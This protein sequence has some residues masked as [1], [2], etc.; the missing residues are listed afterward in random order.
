LQFS[1]ER[2]SGIDCGDLADLTPLAAVAGQ[3][4][5]QGRAQRQGSPR[6]HLG[7][8]SKT[9]PIAAIRIERFPSGI[10]QMPRQLRHPIRCLQCAGRRRLKQELW[11]W[12]RGSHRLAFRQLRV[13][14][15]STPVPP[16]SSSSIRMRSSR[17]PEALAGRNAPQE[18]QS[19]LLNRLWRQCFERFA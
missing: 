17:Q 7:I 16:A 5:F 8:W 9:T 10:V 19:R 11:R 14:K 2:N 18:C 4:K 15:T 12:W 13:T 6:L 1:I 3:L